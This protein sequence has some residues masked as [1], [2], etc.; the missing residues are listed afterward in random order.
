[1]ITARTGKRADA[2][3]DAPE[4]KEEGEMEREKEWTHGQYTVREGLKPG[5]KHLQ[6]FFV[7]SEGGE[8]KC[9]YCVWIEDDALSRFAPSGDFGDIISS[10]R[11][12]W[13]KWV[14]GK[15]D[16]GSFEDLVLK[17]DRAGQKEISLA[18][19]DEK[20]SL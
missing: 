14:Q 11:E 2:P 15:I 3:R 5:S 9:N 19:M 16:D 4:N 20:L 12:S 13:C 7:V 17:V 18:D 8:K 6:Y 10:Q 1:V